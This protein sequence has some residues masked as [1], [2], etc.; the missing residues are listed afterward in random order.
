MLVKIILL[1]K[2]YQQFL[3]RKLVITSAMANEMVTKYATFNLYLIF[4]QSIF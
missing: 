1:W 4:K 2:L 3:L